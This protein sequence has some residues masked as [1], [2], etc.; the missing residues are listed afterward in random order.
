MKEFV[1][2]KFLEKNENKI[3][4]LLSN[5]IFIKPNQ[6]SIYKNEEL[7]DLSQ[8]R[9][10]MIEENLEESLKHIKKIDLKQSYLS[11]WI[12]QTKIY[13]EFKNTLKKVVNIV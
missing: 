5:F 10:Y 9:K 8:A 1:K 11:E 12:S 2:N 13:I 7:N 4:N 3:I 6:K